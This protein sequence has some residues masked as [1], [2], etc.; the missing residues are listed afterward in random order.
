MQMTNY[1]KQYGIWLKAAVMVIVCLF[2]INTLAWAH[3]GLSVN[4][5]GVQSV[6]D[7]PTDEKL[8]KI[9][10]LRELTTNETLLRDA[11]DP[12]ETVLDEKQ[13][14]LGF[15]KCAS[16]KR[17]GGYLMPCW[18]D[19]R[20]YVAYIEEKLAPT[21]GGYIFDVHAYNI[22]EMKT[23]LKHQENKDAFLARL[24][25]ITDDNAPR[26]KGR[27]ALSLFSDPIENVLNFFKEVEKT[28][29]VN[30]NGQK[31][32][33]VSDI[34]C[35][36]NKTAIFKVVGY[37]NVSANE[38]D[39]ASNG[40]IHVKDRKK[41]I[42][43][44]LAIVHEVLAK[45]GI[46]TSINDRKDVKDV[47]R[48]EYIYWKNKDTRFCPKKIGAKIRIASNW[49]IDLAE[50]RFVDMDA[51]EGRDY[52][53]GDSM[54][55]EKSERDKANKILSRSVLDSNLTGPVN[56]SMEMSSFT[57]TPKERTLQW[58]KVKDASFENVDDVETEEYDA[59]WENVEDAVWTE[60]D[61]EEIDRIQRVLKGHTDG[62]DYMNTYIDEDRNITVTSASGD[63]MVR[64]WRIDKEGKVRT[65]V[66]KGHTEIVNH[67]NTHIDGD[68]NITVTSA[69]YDHTVRLWKIDKEGKVRSIVLIGHTET[70]NHTNTHIDGNGNITVTSASYDHMV[71]LW[72]IDKEGKVRSVALKGH[73]D[74][75]YNTNT[76]IDG[77]GNITVTSGAEEE[78]VRLWRI[79]TLD[80]AINLAIELKV[81]DTSLIKKY[82]PLIQYLK[83][84]VENPNY[85]M[86]GV[87]VLPYIIKNAPGINRGKSLLELFDRVMNE[88]DI[89]EFIFQPQLAEDLIDHHEDIQNRIY[90]YKKIRDNILYGRKD[91]DTTSEIEIPLAYTL[92]RG[93]RISNEDARLLD[94]DTFKERI[95]LSKE[96]PAMP[97][98]VEIPPFTIRE[99]KY[100]GAPINK[101]VIRRYH[102]TLK[103]LLHS[104]N[105]FW[106]KAL[107]QLLKANG[108]RAYDQSV[109]TPLNEDFLKKNNLDSVEDIF[110]DDALTM[111]FLKALLGRIALY[112][113]ENKPEF[114]KN[115]RQILETLVLTIIV[116][117]RIGDGERELINSYNDS[118]SPK[119]RYSMMELLK[120]IYTDR[121][122]DVIKAAISG[123]SPDTD[124]IRPGKWDTVK[125]FYENSKAIADVDREMKKVKTETVCEMTVR[126]VPAKQKIDR[127]YSSVAHDC[128]GGNEEVIYEKDF[129]LYRILIEGSKKIDGYVYVAERK[130]GDELVWV[131]PGIQPAPDLDIDYDQFLEKVLD[132]LEGQV[133]KRGVNKILLP[134]DTQYQSNREGMKNAI[135]RAGFDEL[136][137]DEEITFP[138]KGG[139][140]SFTSKE[141]LLARGAANK[142]AQAVFDGAEDTELEKLFN[143]FINLLNT[144][145]ENDKSLDNCTL[146][147]EKYM[148]QI[149][150]KTKLNVIQRC[151]LFSSIEKLSLNVLRKRIAGCICISINN[152]RIVNPSISELKILLNALTK[153]SDSKETKREIALCIGWALRFNHRLLPG[154]LNALRKSDSVL[155]ESITSAFE[156]ALSDKQGPKL[157][158]VDVQVILDVLNRE[159]NTDETRQNIAA[160]MVYSLAHD[161]HLKLNSFQIKIILDRKNRATWTNFVVEHALYN[162]PALISAA[163]SHIANPIPF[164]SGKWLVEVIARSIRQIE[165]D[166]THN[167]LMLLTK[168]VGTEL[169]ASVFN[170]IIEPLFF[171]KQDLFTTETLKAFEEVYAKDVP[172][173]KYMLFYATMGKPFSSSRFKRLFP[174]QKNFRILMSKGKKKVLV[175]H[176]IADGMGDEL[177]RNSTLIQALVDFNPQL[178]VTLYTQ[179]SFLYDHPRV[180]V[181]SVVS[182]DGY[183][184]ED[185]FDLKDEDEFDMVINHYDRKQRYSDS[186]E[187]KFCKYRKQH[188]LK[189][190]I[191]FNKCNDYFI[192]EE[193]IVKGK[194]VNLSGFKGRSALFTP[195]TK[196]VYIPTFRLC[197]ELGLP[198][199]HGTRKPKESIFVSLP[200]TDAQLYWEDVVVSANKD[201]RPIIILSGFGGEDMDKGFQNGEEG[202]KAMFV[203]RVA[204]AEHA[205]KILKNII[206][207]GFFVVLLPGDKFYATPESA[208]DF[209][210]ELSVDYKKYVLIAPRLSENPKLYKYL[211]SHNETAMV[212]AVEGGIM[213]LAY[214]IGAPFLSLLMPKSGYMLQWMS[215]GMDDMQG[216]SDL[217]YTDRVNRRDMAE[218]FAVPAVIKKAVF[219]DGS[220]RKE[221]TESQGANNKDQNLICVPNGFD[222]K[223]IAEKIIELGESGLGIPGDAYFHRTFKVSREEFFIQ[224]CERLARSKL[225]IA[226]KN[227]EGKIIAFTTFWLLDKTTQEN[228][229]TRKVSGYMSEN[230]TEGI[231]AYIPEAYVDVDINNGHILLKK[232]RDLALEYH[233]DIKVF[234]EHV[235]AREGRWYEVKVRKKDR[236]ERKDEIKCASEDIHMKN[237]EFV[238]S[239]GEKRVL[240]HIIA[241]SIIPGE[242]QKQMVQELEQEMRKDKYSEKIVRLEVSSTAD[243]VEELTKEMEKLRKEYRKKGIEID[244]DVAVPDTGINKRIQE[245][246]KTNVLAFRVDEKSFVQVEGI[247]MAL[248]ALHSDSLER[249]YE[250]H[251]LITG[252]ELN[253][254]NAIK[255][256]QDFMREVVFDLPQCRE[257]EYELL[258]ELN[259]NIKKMIMY[260]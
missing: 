84:K 146:R 250:V 258:K 196:N 33:I 28:F 139:D 165:V 75:V 11:V 60:C 210:N 176:N 254:Q 47:L 106:E 68:E 19:G 197:A 190:Y 136:T 111:L 188:C 167:T 88:K 209:I 219:G 203:D 7:H 208:K 85:Q 248:R 144:M 14:I 34:T 24:N 78:T 159:D 168:V 150:T 207:E 70:V 113:Y 16:H 127:N 45:L 185:Q 64:L 253:S 186:F 135:K 233:P 189:T 201:K 112:F 179:R 249:L 221:T 256:I 37:D 44:E 200:N 101:G 124:M 107:P 182:D 192:P 53:F 30:K 66:L 228:V 156:H 83:K 180:K 240:C 57:V 166:I 2:S 86:L 50:C 121:Y 56:S 99:I 119:E 17:L 94:Y 4:A 241:D 212:V 225:L 184:K 193:I 205:G 71:R 204:S 183:F 223:E 114:H 95:L 170:D 171:K 1:K 244:F 98:L 123:I 23:Y 115:V 69:S 117:E 236:S 137:L 132:G 41:S 140:P 76:H 246:L 131:L 157:T 62:L 194:T 12:S 103:T 87:Y 93:A 91:I 31:S 9:A 160:I 80:Q 158:N 26:A 36:A 222:I 178:E 220:N 174:H 104:D 187:E 142:N 242:L 234:C 134:K 3:G 43:L 216:C 65:I 151:A 72:R 38:I 173:F 110:K 42:E 232:M 206:S 100:T 243:F 247:I 8:I 215:A 260:A 39:H 229:R 108:F 199:R 245:E 128:I 35:F 218:A 46:P 214:N 155:L 172:E 55:E 67:T 230:I 10:L 148:Y 257:L 118:S 195:K 259:E 49:T 40:A 163:I 138:R 61:L 81:K 29:R 13:I 109:I 217:H 161:P 152:R 51:L 120:N 143:E 74:K 125:T 52:S 102:E 227:P 213:H 90:E 251:K 162:N 130:V 77:D 122:P 145:D 235:A 58:E 54:E 21:G 27:V 154:M 18:V 198:F 181:K 211:I 191:N 105:V 164:D 96:L 238:P 32:T 129:Y 255:S 133:R 147:L 231:H 15:H 141:F 175:V 5:L 239:I 63:S 82:V 202:K 149:T 97:D 89:T 169:K 79:P 22:R 237:L 20:K 6:F 126:L 252:K 25:T 224:Y 177:I 48:R 226:V 59:V 73:T 153:D 92:V 116:K